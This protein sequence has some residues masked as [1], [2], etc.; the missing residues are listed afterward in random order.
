MSNRTSDPSTRTHAT[1]PDLAREVS[2]GALSRREFLTRATALGVGRTM[3]LS[4]IGTHCV[5]RPDPAGAQ[6]TQPQSQPATDKTRLRIQMEVRALG[7]PRRY[8]WS[9]LGNATRGLLQYL[10]RY[11][12][13]GS[14]TGSLLDRWEASEDASEYLLYLRPGVTWNDGTP[15]TAEDVAANF[16]GWADW[17]V[18]GNSM[19]ARLSGL[20]DPVTLRA[21]ADGIEV[22]DALTLRIRLGGPDVTF[23]PSIADYPAAV[24]RQDLIGTD[25]RDH[26]IGTGAYRI[27]EY[28][29][30]RIAVLERIAGQATWTGAQLDRVEFHDLGPDPI[31]WHAAALADEIDMTYRAEPM[32]MGAFNELGW[33]LSSVDTATTIVV[34]G[35]QTAEI[36]GARPY[37]DRRVRRALALAV[38]NAVCLELGINGLGSVAANDHVAP[39]HPDHAALRPARHD[40]AEAR[41]LLAAAGMTDFVHELVS[42]DDNWR[43]N[44]ADAVGAQLLDAGIRLERRIVPQREYSARWTQYPFSTTNWNHRPL[45]VQVLAL[46]YRSGVAWNES[47]FADATF[48]TLLGRATAIADA[49]TRRNTMAEL[50]TILREEGV[51][52]QPFWQS[53]FR[54]ARE[55]LSGVQM[56][57]TFDI[58]IHRIAWT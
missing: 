34:R 44:T 15:F 56:H 33:Q 13:D 57:P 27:T 17:T 23:I 1:L 51:I 24:Q 21:K 5:L 22:L 7:D 10:V 46:A 18:T 45:G 42:V 29:P 32:F 39:I 35:R 41:E 55:G 9:E 31:A 11:R 19:A 3:A 6:A 58:D 28:D 43:R 50:Q 20:T 36:D 40:P 12:A 14:F 37:A 47:G 53:L 49:E 52:I 48:D 38:D 25:P 2:D 8:D 30:G 26:N 54:H 4:A 16:E